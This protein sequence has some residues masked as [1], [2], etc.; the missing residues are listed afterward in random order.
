MDGQQSD[1]RSE[2]ILEEEIKKRLEE[3]IMKRQLE[4]PIKELEDLLYEVYKNVQEVVNNQP[5]S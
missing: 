1:E 5:N 4:Y 2:K 3:E